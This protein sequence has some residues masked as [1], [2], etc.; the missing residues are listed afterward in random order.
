MLQTVRKGLQQGSFCI[1]QVIRNFVCSIRR[2]CRY[3]CAW[4]TLQY[5]ADARLLLLL[6]PLLL[7][8][9]LL[10]LPL[11]SRSFFWVAGKDSSHGFFGFCREGFLPLFFWLLQAMLS[12]DGHGACFGPLA[13]CPAYM[14]GVKVTRGPLFEWSGFGHQDVRYEGTR[15]KMTVGT[16]MRPGEDTMGCWADAVFD[17]WEDGCN[18][19]GGW[20][21]HRSLAVSWRNNKLDTYFYKAGDMYLLTVLQ[22]LPVTSTTYCDYC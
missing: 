12:T 3:C 4:G 11:P 7:L 1:L 2:T 9:L 17:A 16:S 21:P 15:A 6:L 10:L 14:T 18:P 19:F 22:Q 20:C 5:V 8:L 13:P